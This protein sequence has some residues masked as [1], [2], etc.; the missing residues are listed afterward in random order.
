MK[1]LI[2]FMMQQFLPGVILNMLS[3]IILTQKLII[4]GILSMFNL[5]IKEMNS[6]TNPV[7]LKINL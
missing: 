7:Y 4:L 3:D 1:E 6:L 5:S 2:D